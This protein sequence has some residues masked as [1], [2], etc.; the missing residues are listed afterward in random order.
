MDDT[1]E[2]IGFG[3]CNTGMYH[4]IQTFFHVNQLTSTYINGVCFFF[5]LGDG[6]IVDGNLNS[7][8]IDSNINCVAEPITFEDNGVMRGKKFIT[9]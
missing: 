9:L 1:H 2:D 5:L 8:P 7:T 6:V 4:A 3:D